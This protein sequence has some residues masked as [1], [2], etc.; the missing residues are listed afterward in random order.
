M[1]AAI[2]TAGCDVQKDRIEVEVVAWG[3]D[4]ESWSIIYRIFLGDTAK[5]DV[6]RELDGFLQETYEHEGGTR[7]RLS[8]VCVDT[9]YN[10]KQVYDFVRERQIRNIFAIKGSNQAGVPIISDRPPKRQKMSKVHLFLVGTESA[11]QSIYG[12]LKVE[13]PG[14]GYMHFP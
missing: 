12:R 10:T 4:E 3:R 2:L 9:G 14:P 11:K 5:I 1:G 6:W 13:E 8:A 7:L